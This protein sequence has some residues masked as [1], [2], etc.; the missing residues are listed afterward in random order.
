[1]LSSEACTRTAGAPLLDLAMDAYTQSGF[2]GGLP[3]S[4]PTSAATWVLSQPYVFLIAAQRLALGLV[5]SSAVG[6]SAGAVFG[7]TTGTL[8]AYSS[9]IVRYATSGLQYLTAV[10]TG[11]APVAG[12]EG[13]GALQF[14]PSLMAAPVDFTRSPS[15]LGVGGLS[16]EASVVLGTTLLGV[17]QASAALTPS[18]ALNLLAFSQTFYSASDPYNALWQIACALRDPALPAPL[19]LLSY[20]TL[21]ASDRATGAKVSTPF[22]LDLGAWLAFADA[23]LGSA[24][25]TRYSVARPVTEAVNYGVARYGSALL[26]NASRPPC[27]QVTWPSASPS[28]GSTPTPS[29]TPSLSPGASPSSTPTAA[30]S[31]SPGSGG[32]GGGGGG[33]ASAA[34]AAP[35]FSQTLVTGIAVGT[36]LGGCAVGALLA[37][38]AFY[39]RSSGSGSGAAAS[40][41]GAKEVT[42]PFAVAAA[43]GAPRAEVELASRAQAAPQAWRASGETAV[44]VAPR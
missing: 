20:G 22:F 1:M 44:L 30:A 37:G 6:D 11:V 39:L 23:L 35:A 43:G 41:A 8:N 25:P 31:A 10:L 5:S 15:G 13:S 33:G 2:S 21:A 29:P 4:N 19:P 26:F 40:G 18:G 16:G 38:C 28:P 34:A 17:A 9:A 7:G 32:G 12:F 14:G 27:P 24:L 36:A 3:G 42:N